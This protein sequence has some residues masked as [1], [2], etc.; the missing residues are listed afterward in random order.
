MAKLRLPAPTDEKNYYLDDGSILLPSGARV[1]PGQWMVIYC[2][3]YRKIESREMQ[4][5]GREIRYFNS[6]TE[7]LGYV[8]LLREKGAKS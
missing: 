1:E 7:A 4:F 6:A 2:R 8:N 3:E 5:D